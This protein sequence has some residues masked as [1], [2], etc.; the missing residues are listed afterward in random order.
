[1]GDICQGCKRSPV[2]ILE[3]LDDPEEPY[4]VCKDCYHRLMAHSLRPKEW[5]NLSSVHGRLNDLLSNE[6]YNEDNGTALQPSEEVL[7]AESH[8]CPT[9]PEVCTSPESLLT[10]ILTR[11][12]VHEAGP[13]AKWFIHEDLVRAMQKHSAGALL[14]VFSERLS[15]IRNIEITRTIFHLIGLTLG[16]RGA[17]LVRDNW[18][19]VAATGA[20]SGIAFAASMCLPRDEAHKKVAD[21]LSEMDRKKRSVAKHV[22]HW[23]QSPSN[24]DWME[25][26][27][28]S[29]VDSSWG[30]LAASS[31]FD[32]ERAKKWLNLGRPL[33][34]IALDA[35]I[36]C[37]CSDNEAQL[38]NSPS[39]KEFISVLEDYLSKDNVPRVRERV[40]EL[41]ERSQGRTG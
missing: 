14:A 26:N 39:S 21:T 22:L 7:G 40:K 17:G 6:Y 5:Y 34:L 33:S 13:I 24:L 8:P 36:W 18:E 10:Y 20:F 29:P 23:F 3:A 19:R 1:M 35:L 31:Q 4:E 9:F 16:T 32:W 27:A 41:L 11:D 12:H 30:R 38:V 2:H 25:E 37:V 28:H 15:I